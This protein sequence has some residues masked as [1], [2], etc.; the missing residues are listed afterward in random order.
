[1]FA[2]PVGAVARL[3]LARALLMSGDRARARAAYEDF[4]TLW[5]DADQDIPIL[6][7]A[8]AESAKLR[9]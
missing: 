6:K 3:Q 4:L 5:K 2:D 8:R 1:V 9:M 7:E